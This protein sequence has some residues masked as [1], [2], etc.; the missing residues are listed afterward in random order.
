MSKRTSNT[1]AVL[2][3]ALTIASCSGC[4]FGGGS[5][6]YAEP[7]A[8]ATEETTGPWPPVGPVTCQTASTCF[9]LGESDASSERTARA[10]CDTVSGTLRPGQPCGGG[11]VGICRLPPGRGASHYYAPS[12]DATSGAEACR[13]Q[14]SAQ[15]EPQ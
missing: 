14:P 8:E 3:G 7:V 2:V 5:P 1:I 12:W 15:W 6:P 10:W 4:C 11:A 9:E 13:A